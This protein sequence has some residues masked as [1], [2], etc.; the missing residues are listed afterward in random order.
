MSF[1]N[2]KAFCPSV[3][4]IEMLSPV[5]DEVNKTTVNRIVKVF[6]KVNVYKITANVQAFVL[7]GLH[8]F[9]ALGDGSRT[10]N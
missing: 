2:L 9:V 1:S 6:F 7:L 3:L 4:S 5:F 10:K 8:L